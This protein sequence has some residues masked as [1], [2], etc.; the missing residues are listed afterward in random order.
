[1]CQQICFGIVSTN[2]YTHTITVQSRGL[3][4]PS[5]FL[6]F[7]VTYY[8]QIVG[9]H[10]S[11]SCPCQLDLSFLGFTKCSPVLFSVGL[12]TFNA[13]FQME[14]H[15]LACI[16]SL[17]PFN[18]LNAP[19]HQGA[20]VSIQSSAGG[21]LGWFH[22]EVIVNSIVVNF[23]VQACMIYEHVFSFTLSK[24][25]RI[26][27]CVWS[28]GKYTLTLI[29]IVK[30]FSKVTI[31]FCLS[32][33]KTDVLHLL[34]ILVNVWY[35]QHFTCQSPGLCFD[36]IS[37]FMSVKKEPEGP[38]EHS[39]QLLCY[40]DCLQD[41]PYGLQGHSALWSPSTLLDFTRNPRIASRQGQVSLMSLFFTPFQ[42]WIFR[43]LCHLIP[44]SNTSWC[45]LGSP[46]PANTSDDE[47]LAGCF[48]SHLCRLFHSVICFNEEG[49]ESKWGPD[50]PDVPIGLNNFLSRCSNAVKRYHDPAYFGKG[51]HSAGVCL[52]FQRFSSLSAW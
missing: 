35:C 29:A 10:W 19:L 32:T 37:W 49:E 16:R 5:S 33:I 42:W 22:S 8:F 43:S 48:S 40:A 44:Q 21:H 50:V 30:L 27:L 23:H 4:L 51:K 13:L 14:I 20:L 6:P 11:T 7:A 17:P 1:M 45:L 25:L 26:Q 24:Y 52:P 2:L 3:Y 9:N 46:G 31:P 38:V 41:G 15:P 47:R 12:F 28:H 36:F 34:F 39:A 18:V